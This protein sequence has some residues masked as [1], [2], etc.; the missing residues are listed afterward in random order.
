MSE[1]V[2][3]GRKPAASESSHEAAESQELLGLT[4]CVHPDGSYATVTLHTT[5]GRIRFDVP[6]EQMSDLDAEIHQASL[7][8]L[9]RQTTSTDG[10]NP[11]DELIRTALRPSKISVKV[12]RS[13]GDKLFI[14]QF[15]DR[16]AR[17]LRV[18]TEDVNTAIDDVQFLTRQASN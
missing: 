16:M 17:V 1:S 11:V 6:F 2:R 10:R 8:M 14:H 15:P 13:N 3:A 5:Q 9:Y 12:D 4:S 18:S 7:L